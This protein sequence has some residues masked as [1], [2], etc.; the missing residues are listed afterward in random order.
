MQLKQGDG[1]VPIRSDNPNMPYI[2]I[3][4]PSRGEFDSLWGKRVAGG[5]KERYW[6]VLTKRAQG[7][8]LTDAGQEV[9]ISG[10]RVRQIEAKFISLIQHHWYTTRASK[11][12]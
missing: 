10:E 3:P 11:T 9:G 5:S 2:M 8:T 7:A 6:S 4:F 12:D 1:R